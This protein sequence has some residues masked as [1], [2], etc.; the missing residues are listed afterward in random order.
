[1]S[2]N[3]E[4]KVPLTMPGV[5]TWLWIAITF[6][7]FFTHFSMVFYNANRDAIQGLFR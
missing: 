3:L 5:L 1:M 6:I 2:D 7:L 4:K